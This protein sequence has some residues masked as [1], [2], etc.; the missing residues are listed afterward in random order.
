M[1]LEEAKTRIFSA[2]DDE[3]RAFVMKRQSALTL[4]AIDVSKG[5]ISVNDAVQEIFNHCSNFTD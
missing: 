1:T 3:S 4:A 5:T 2:L